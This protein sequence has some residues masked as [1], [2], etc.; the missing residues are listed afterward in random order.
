[1]KIDGVEI[2]KDKVEIVAQSEKKYQHQKLGTIIPHK[3]HTLFQI[4]YVTG[5]VTVAEF[6]KTDVELS[7][8]GK[9]A[10]L[11]KIR[12][13]VL[14]KKDCIYVSA[15]NIRNACIKFEKKAKKLL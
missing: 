10:N 1:M 3:G 7:R 8:L 5:E 12:H 13:R 11:K 2:K 9:E 4:N 6:E 14:I 15:L